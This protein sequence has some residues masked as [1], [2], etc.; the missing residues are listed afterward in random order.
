MKNQIALLHK[1]AE[2]KRA[3]TKAKVEKLFWKQRRRRLSA[4]PP[5]KP[6]RKGGFRARCSCFSSEFRY[7]GF[8]KWHFRGFFSSFVLCF[9]FFRCVVMWFM[10]RNICLMLHYLVCIVM[11]LCV[12]KP[13][14]KKKQVWM[15]LF[16]VLVKFWRYRLSVWWNALKNVCF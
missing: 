14:V 10:W 6:Q 13:F 9:C 11:Q 12:Y 1:N 4:E 8:V 2:E 15:W 16:Y 5:E 3:M 7:A